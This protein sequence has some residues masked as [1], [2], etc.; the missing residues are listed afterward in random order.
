MK[1]KQF[2]F[3]LGYMTAFIT[4]FMTMLLISCSVTPLD[5]VSSSSETSGGCGEYEYNPC[6]VKVVE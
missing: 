4:A 5:A 3:L 1:D 6:F 2:Y